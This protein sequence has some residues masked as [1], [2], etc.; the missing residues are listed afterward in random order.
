VSCAHT[1]DDLLQTLPATFLHEMQHLIDFSQHVVLHGGQEEAGWLDEGLSIVAE[2]LGSLYYEQRFPP[3][4]GRTDPAQLFPDS[5]QGFIAD[6]LPD[7][8]DYLLLT[9]TSTVTLHTDADDG[10]AWRGGD[11]LLLRWLGD[12]EPAGFYQ[13]L[14]QGTQT[15]AANIAAA[16][17]EPFPT[18]FGDFGVSLY[19]D[20]VPGLA[21][22]AVPTRYRYTTRTLRAMY[23]RLFVNDAQDFPRAFPIAPAALRATASASML[24]GTMS[25]YTLATTGTTPVTIAFTGTGGA[26][27]SSTLHPQIT[28]VRLR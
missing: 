13:R 20:S 25:Y 18:L 14:E 19:T 6:L 7:S 8:Y 22:S 16:A 23:Q 1:V 27:L 17:G 28:V 5:S 21:K 12:H 3:P 4:S 15:G 26:P 11:W 24:P 2:E 9:D 10:L